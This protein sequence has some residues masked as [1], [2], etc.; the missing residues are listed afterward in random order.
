MKIRLANRLQ[1]ATLDNKRSLLNPSVVYSLVNF[2]YSS[3]LGTFCVAPLES[4]SL[5]ATDIRAV[6]PAVPL[7]I[8]VE[9]VAALCS[10]VLFQV[11]RK[12]HVSVHGITL[13]VVET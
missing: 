12:Q 8:F 2:L 5:G 6:L 9:E 7:Q 13:Q 3:D 1:V 11:E 10:S 4:L